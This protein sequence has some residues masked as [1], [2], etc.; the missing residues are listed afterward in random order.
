MIGRMPEQTI[1]RNNYFH[2]I[3][4][5]LIGDYRQAIDM[6]DGSTNF[7]VYNNLC[8]DIAISIREGENRIVENNIVINPV[9]PFGMHVLYDGNHDVVRHNIIVTRGD[10]YHMNDAPPTQ[11]WLEID[12]NLFFNDAKPWGY[13]PYITVQPRGEDQRKYSLEQWQE[14]GYDVHSRYADPMFV[15]PDHGDYRVRQDS[16]ALELGFRN[17]AMDFGLTDEFPTMWVEEQSS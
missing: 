13:K 10:V 11:P 6:D 4:G 1:I 16:P 12:G 17:F 2:G 15:D 5:Y 9:V 3:E 7:H 14:L 8:V